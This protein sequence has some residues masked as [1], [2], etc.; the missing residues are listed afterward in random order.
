M[1][2]LNLIGEKVGKSFDCIGTGDN[3]PEQ[4]RL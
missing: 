2:T 1:D 3:F 4:N